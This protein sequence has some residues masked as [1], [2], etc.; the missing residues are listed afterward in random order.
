[1]LPQDRD[2]RSK[3]AR[4]TLV[5]LASCIRLNSTVASDFSVQLICRAMRTCL[6]NA[7]VALRKA[8]QGEDD[9]AMEKAESDLKVWKVIQALHR[10]VMHD[11]F[12]VV[13]LLVLFGLICSG[14]PQWQRRL[15]QFDFLQR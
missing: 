3:E 10:Y 7:H 2:R 15:T 4:A 13:S 12:E 8:Y 14:T 11:G 1:M 9:S 5:A 6:L